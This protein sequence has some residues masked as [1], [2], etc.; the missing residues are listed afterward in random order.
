M[1]CELSPL[2]SITDEESSGTIAARCIG[3]AK[4]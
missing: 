1:N 4:N 3:I 2:H